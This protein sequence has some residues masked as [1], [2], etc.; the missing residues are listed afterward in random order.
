MSLKR[1]FL[2]VSV[3]LLLASCGEESPVKSAQ[4]PTGPPDTTNNQ[5][6]TA[7]KRQ[8]A[9][10]AESA[11][12]VSV[13]ILPEN[14]TSSGCLRAVIQGIPG[15]ASV[16]WSV[17]GEVVSSGTETQLCNDRYKRGDLVTVVVGTV[18]KGA[19]TSV[20]IADSPPRIVNITS[21]PAEIFTGTDIVVEPVAEDVDGDQ[22]DF[23]YQ[24]LING[25][26]DPLLTE[27][28]LPGNRF[29]KG[30][31]LQVL[32]VPND[33]FMDGP[34]YQSYVMTV[35]NAA[36]RITSEPPREITSLDYRYQV[37]VSDPDDKQFTYRLAEAPHGMTIDENGG[38]I[39][40]SLAGVAPGDYTIAIIVA[41]PDGAEAAQ[42]FKLTLGAPQ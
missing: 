9:P 33:F 17:N 28:T 40:W 8:V 15:S 36:P 13:R 3:G 39:R 11:G 41:D 6:Q 31:R 20:S 35:P 14:P 10:A 38:L 4:G 30:D 42:E 5:Q 26:A 23:T 29:R 19:Q 22:V 18:E 32:I 34:T 37:K 7:I 27:A 24:W 1:L 2:I 16:R 21:T 25:D 12:G